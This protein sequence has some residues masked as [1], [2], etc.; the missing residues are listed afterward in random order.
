[1][2]LKEK[3]FIFTFLILLLLDCQEPIISFLRPT[4][5]LFLLGGETIKYLSLP[6]GNK[7]EKEGE[8]GE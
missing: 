8:K 1:M 3:T 7:K 5:H 6:P 4:I 2:Q